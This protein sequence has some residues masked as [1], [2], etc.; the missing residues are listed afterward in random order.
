[1]Q[2]SDLIQAWENGG[3]EIN[4]RNHLSWLFFPVLQVRTSSTTQNTKWVMGGNLFCECG[5]MKISLSL[6]VMHL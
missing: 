2:A 4:V 3:W 5:S 1:M 6:L